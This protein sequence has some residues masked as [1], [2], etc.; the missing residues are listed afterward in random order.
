MDALI[1]FC[2]QRRPGNQGADQGPMAGQMIGALLDDLYYRL[3][4][5]RL[6]A[7]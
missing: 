7:L 4:A 1:R 6:N 5:L 2:R 3:S